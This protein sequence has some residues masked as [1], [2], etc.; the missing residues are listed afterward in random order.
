MIKPTIRLAGSLSLA[1]ALLGGAAALIHG[2][3]NAAAASAAAPVAAT[4]PS[5]VR[6]LSIPAGTVIRVR[7]SRALDTARNRAGDEFSATLDSPV[8]VNGQE[9]LPK[10]TLFRGHVTESSPSGRLRG[11]AILAGELDSVTL[12]GA[13]YHISTSMNTRVSSS[14]RNRNLLAIGGGSVAGAMI[15]GLAGGGVGALAGAGAGAAAGTGGA[16]LTGKKNVYLPAESILSFRL[17][18]PLEVRE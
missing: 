15:G 8:N 9:A 4:K 7:I 12:R 11:R 3:V 18:T 2:R 5:P 13:T 16:A 1:L 10:H 14:H 17:K 6:T